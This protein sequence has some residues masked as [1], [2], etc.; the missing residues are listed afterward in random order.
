[1]VSAGDHNRQQKVAYYKESFNGFP[2]KWAYYWEVPKPQNHK[3]LALCHNP[4][5]KM[6][7]TLLASLMAVAI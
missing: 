4:R 7:K 3:K 1:M 2:L 5:D 6:C